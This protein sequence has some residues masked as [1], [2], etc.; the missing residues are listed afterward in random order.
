MEALWIVLAVAAVGAVIYGSY[1]LRKKRREELA[2]MARQLGLSYSRG[3]HGGT[4]RS[5]VRAP[6]PG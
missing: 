1:W 5:S 2:L 3:G 4:P 6:P